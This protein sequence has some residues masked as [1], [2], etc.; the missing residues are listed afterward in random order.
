MVACHENQL[1]RD[2]K[3][4]NPK[5]LPDG[6]DQSSETCK[7]EWDSWMFLDAAEDFS[8]EMGIFEPQE[9]SLLIY[10]QNVQVAAREAGI[11]PIGYPGPISDFTDLE[12]FKSNVVM[13]RKLG[14]EGGSCIHPKQVSILNKAFTPTRAEIE[15]S[16]QIIAAYSTALASHD[17]A[18]ALGGKMIDLPIV[19]RAKRILATR[20]MIY[21]K[22]S[23]QV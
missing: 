20:D 5:N 15:R 4:L 17:G 13:A 18:I 2:A 7:K 3:E 14:F 9:V 10:L 11:I 22:I 23:K 12:L 6:P 16:E 21:S 19:A 1:K 8:A